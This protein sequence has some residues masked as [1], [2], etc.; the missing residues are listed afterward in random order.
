MIFVETILKGAF[1][2]EAQRLEDERGFF[3]RVFCQ[4]DFAQHGLSTAIAQCN[5]SFNPRK[6]TLRGM[7]YQVAPFEE[8]K[9]IRCTQGAIHDVIVDLRP[10]S[11]TFR[12]W[13]GVELSAENRKMLYVPANFAHG[14]LTLE[15][16]T[17]VFYQMSQ[18]YSGEHGRGVRWNDPAFNIQWPMEPMIMNDRDRTCP[19]FRAT[20]PQA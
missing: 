2:I 16:N 7:H 18:F 6:G 14:F 12:K 10:E 1:V 15:D 3:A 17:E 11:S 9:V 5:V 8:A 4:R 19:D 13:T 20:E